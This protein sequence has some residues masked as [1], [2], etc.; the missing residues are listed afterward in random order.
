MTNFESM[1]EFF[2]TFGGWGVSAVLLTGI[3][4][5]YKTQITAQTEKDKQFID[6]L[7]ET[8]SVL[9]QN[10]DR[11]DRVEAVLSRVERLLDKWRGSLG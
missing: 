4:Y 8:V 9:Q 1:A 6:V 10:A 7:K 5:L 11:N 2:Q 3:I